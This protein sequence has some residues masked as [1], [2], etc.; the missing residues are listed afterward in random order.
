M[1]CYK[2]SD[3]TYVPAL[4]GMNYTYASKFQIYRPFIQTIKEQEQLTLKKIDFGFFSH[5]R[6]KKVG[7]Y[8]I[9]K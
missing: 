4:I 6:K 1:F 9:S 2:N 3:Q 5:F 7:R 8:N